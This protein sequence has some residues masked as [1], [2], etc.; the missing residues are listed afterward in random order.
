MVL[1]STIVAISVYFYTKRRLPQHTKELAALKRDFT[2]YYKSYIKTCIFIWIVLLFSHI[3][4]IMGVNMVLQDPEEIKSEGVLFNLGRL[5]NTCKIM[6]P[7]LLFFI[8]I[9]DPLLRK[10]IW[11]PFKKL[12]KSVSTHS[13]KRKGSINSRISNVGDLDQ[14]AALED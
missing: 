4:E 9:Q 6:M 2:N 12:T 3:C 1:F 10:R 13:K 11:T 7:L 14:I 5:G 8:R